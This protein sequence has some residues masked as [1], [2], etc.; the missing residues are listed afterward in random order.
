[1]E[2]YQIILHNVSDYLISRRKLFQILLAAQK[3]F[4]AQISQSDVARTWGVLYIR[5]DQT[6]HIYDK[7]D[8]NNPER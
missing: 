1:M 2:M 6:L 4:F 8:F 7:Q 3:L 5:S